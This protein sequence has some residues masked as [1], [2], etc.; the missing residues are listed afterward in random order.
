[1]GGQVLLKYV[2]GRKSLFFFYQF[3]DYGDLFKVALEPPVLNEL[4][5]LAQTTIFLDHHKTTLLV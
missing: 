3:R 1:M 2:K 4:T 5:T